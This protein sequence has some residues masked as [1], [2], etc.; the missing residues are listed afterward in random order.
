MQRRP[1]DDDARLLKAKDEITRIVGKSFPVMPEVLQ[2]ETRLTGR[3]IN[4]PYDATMRPMREHVI[5]IVFGG[6]ATATVCVDGRKVVAPSPVGAVTI[7]PSGHY[8][9][10][11]LDGRIEVSNIYLGP[12]RLQSF[13]DTLAEGRSFELLDRVNHPDLRLLAVMGLIAT[14]VERPRQHSCIYLEQALDLVCLELLRGHSTL[15]RITQL[16]RRGLPRFQVR[17]V[18]DYMRDHLAEDVSLQELADLVGMS[19]YHFCTAF[20]MATG[21]APH[22]TLT[23]LRLE[24]A[25]ELLRF[26]RL[27]IIEVAYSVGYTSPSSF[28][29]AFRRQLGISPRE[30]RSQA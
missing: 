27:P 13:A 23:R 30:Y 10:Y 4:E 28:S 20:R 24:L 5:A 26:S 19:R 29:A 17:K 25:C 8:G 11:H 15:A 9:H 16:P 22:E 14:E 21:A 7:A 18:I 6:R 2:G 3:W 1:P 12:E